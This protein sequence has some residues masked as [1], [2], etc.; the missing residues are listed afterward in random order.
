MAG[1]G[2]VHKHRRRARRCQRGGDLAP[3][4]SALAHAHDD[5]PTTTGQHD[6]NGLH[7]LLTHPLSQVLHGLRLDPEGLTGQRQALDCIERD[8]WTHRSI[9]VSDLPT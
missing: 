3:D 2:R 9:L 6:L 8:G 5:D 7:E 1:L 4:V